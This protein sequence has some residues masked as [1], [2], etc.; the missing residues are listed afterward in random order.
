VRVC[1]NST[2]LL[3]QSTPPSG[4]RPE[5]ISADVMLVLISIHAPERGATYSPFLIRQ[6]GLFQS[7]PPERG[8]TW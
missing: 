1:S 3:F 5:S 4:E 2:V 7:T 8:A 6:A